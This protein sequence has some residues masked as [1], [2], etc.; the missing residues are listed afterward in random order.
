MM[1]NNCTSC[2]NSSYGQG[3]NDL[4]T[5][6][7]VKAGVEDSTTLNSIICRST[8]G[9]TCGQD[10]MPKGSRFGLSQPNRDTLEM[11]KLE[12]FCN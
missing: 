2:H 3:A 1:A 7:Q 6:N 8:P 12:G 11:W 9:Q 5:Y 4:T 10:L